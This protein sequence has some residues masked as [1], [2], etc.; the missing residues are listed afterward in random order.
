MWVSCGS[1]TSIFVDYI[2]YF[3]VGARE[4]K[5]KI[6]RETK[7]NVGEFGEKIY[8]ANFSLFF[9]GGSSNLAFEISFAVK[10]RD[11]NSICES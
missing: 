9:A 1:V 6:V 10:E 5:W 11:V 3:Y 8:S 7:Y 2:I 4:V